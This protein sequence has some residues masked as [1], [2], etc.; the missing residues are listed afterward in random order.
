MGVTLVKIDISKGLVT[1]VTAEGV[2]KEQFFS[3]EDAF[4]KVAEYMDLGYEVITASA[5]F[6]VLKKPQPL[7]GGK[8]KLNLRPTF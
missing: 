8:D 5:D 2:E 3:T 6:Y 1:T 4:S 7:P